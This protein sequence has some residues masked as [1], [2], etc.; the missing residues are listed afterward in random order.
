[1]TVINDIEQKN[2][3]K[4]VDDSVR[5]YLKQIG[6]I[7]LLKK[8]EEV[9]LAK[10]IAQ[11]SEEAKQKL[12][13]AN[14]RLVVSISKKY[15]GKGIH[16]LD[17]IQEGNIGLMRAIDKF[18]HTKGFK[19]STYATWWIRQAIT[20]AIADQARTIRVPVHMIEAI[21]K[22]IK[23]ER[24]L[25]IELG[26]EPKLEELAKA[27]NQEPKKVAE[28]LEVSKEVISLDYTIGDDGDQSNLG[29][30]VEDKET[31][32]PSDTLIE[33]DLKEQINE[34]LNTLTE[35]EE[36]V[37]RLRFGLDGGQPQTLQE[38][39]EIFGITRERVRQIES[40]ALE[41]LKQPSRSK[42]VKVFL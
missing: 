16:L 34:L 6:Q 28:I 37:I 13:E 2:E 4:G 7:P 25:T 30:F 36:E 24:Q 3:L 14:L 40:K 12:M 21:N 41:K 1:M 10:Q 27:T 15:A 22:T 19:F 8:H 33:K 38:V 32:S 9:E 17:L 42:K 5:L 39:G 23:A 20:R 35:R 29:D 18:D 31:Q 26:R 11:G